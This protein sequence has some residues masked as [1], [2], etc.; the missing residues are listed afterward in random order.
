MGEECKN[1]HNARS[2]SR[3]SSPCGAAISFAERQMQNIA[4]DDWPV[5]PGNWVKQVGRQWKVGS[6]CEIDT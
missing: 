3:V 5:E 6:P 4:G 1:R 2:T